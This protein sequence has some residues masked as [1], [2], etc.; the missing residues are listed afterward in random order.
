MALSNELLEEIVLNL[1]PEERKQ[2]FSQLE[3]QLEQDKKD[4]SEGKEPISPISNSQAKIKPHTSNPINCYNRIY[5]C[6]HCGSTKI[7]SHGVTSACNQR[8]ICI[9]CGKTFTENHGKSL[10]FTHISKDTW[11][12]ILRG[13]VYNHSDTIIAHDNNLAVSTVWLCKQKVCNA[14]KEM[15]GYN[16]LFSGT[17]EADEYYCRAAFK[18]KRDTEFFIYTLGRMPR[19][20]RNRQEKIE[21]LEENGL[22][23][24]LQKENP[25]YLEELLSDNEKIKRGI[26]NEQICIL[27]LVD[28]NNT[29]YLEP[30]SVGRLEKAMA[31]V[32]LKQKFTGNNNVLVVL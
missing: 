29:L 1:T 2:L 4:I 12:N 21:W 13:F 18:G 19:H 7:K 14:I 31:K 32:K 6:V 28:E 10:R 15:Y 11:L 8:Y 17:S 5:C 24:R 30:V 22:Y 26:S 27:T 25:S 20:H 3:K 23:E 16:D 9:D